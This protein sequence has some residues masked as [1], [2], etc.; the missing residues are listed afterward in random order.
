VPELTT[1][2][3]PHQGIGYE[4]KISWDDEALVNGAVAFGITAARFPLDAVDRR[5]EVKASVSIQREGED[6]IL[7]IRVGEWSAP[8]LRLRE[9][10]AGTVVEEFIE[11][12]PAMDPIVGCLVRSGI[13]ATAGQLIHCKNESE[14]APW[15]QQRARAIG[16]CLREHVYDIGFRTAFRAG[17]CIAR[18]GF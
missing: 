13:S 15:F 3:F 11:A 1:V 6:P 5:E 14:D 12:I 2:R 18:L 9:L 4:L 8:P 7:V 16:R 17:R 10:S